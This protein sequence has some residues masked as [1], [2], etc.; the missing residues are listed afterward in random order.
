MVHC[1][2]ENSGENAK[3]R[4]S[5]VIGE[6]TVQTVMIS[7]IAFMPMSSGAARLVIT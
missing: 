1:C 6:S 4:S 3:C 7:S 2:K 5:Q